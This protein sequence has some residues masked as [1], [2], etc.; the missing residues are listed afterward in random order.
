MLVGGQL[1]ADEQQSLTAGGTS[2]WANLETD[3]HDYEEDQHSQPDDP[4]PTTR[5]DRRGAIEQT[6]DPFQH[7][8]QDTHRERGVVSV[9][10]RLG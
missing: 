1:A 7:P 6:A 2:E 9:V 10:D 3:R 8:T 4:E 5:A